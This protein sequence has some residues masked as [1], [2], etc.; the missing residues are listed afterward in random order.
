MGHMRTINFKINSKDSGK[1]IK[2]FL[3][4]FGVSSSLIT[5]LKQSPAGI[6][7]NGRGAKAID[8]L[9]A[10]D[11]LQINIES[12][13]KM[14]TLSGAEVEI[15]YEDEDL[16]AVN[17]PPFMPVHESRN[18][19][20]DTLSNAIAGYV[21]ENTAFRAIYRLDKDTSG[22]V[23]VAKNELAAGK[24]AGN[25]KKDYYAVATKNIGEEGTI[26]A[27]IA[28]EGDSI[29]KR[30]VRPDGESA[31]THYTRVKIGENGTLYKI[32]LDTGRTHQIRV[33]FAHMGSP[34][35]GD[36]LYGGNDKLIKRQALHC[37]NIYFE[38]PIT[39]EEIKVESNLPQDMLSLI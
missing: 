17:K 11:E 22:I 5:K 37:K 6:K 27:P 9:T 18:H 33:H 28:R 13:G 3:K 20:G 19:R 32:H 26:N 34:L 24:L 23:L 25:V 10:G 21:D 12:H 29:I 38:H 35:V 4:S 39:G 7:L 30:C 1:K 31:V 16:I 14:P 8:T 36:T 15:L 2:D